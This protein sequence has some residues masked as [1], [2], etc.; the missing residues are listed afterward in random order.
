MG[1]RLKR[2]KRNN[3]EVWRREKLESRESGTLEKGPDRKYQIDI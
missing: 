1:H 2:V 3:R